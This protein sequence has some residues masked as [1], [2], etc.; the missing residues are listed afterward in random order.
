[1]DAEQTP[2]AVVPTAADR[3]R[4]MI[5]GRPILSAIL[6][7]LVWHVVQFALAEAIA[8]SEDAILKMPDSNS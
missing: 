3:A 4:A 1:M 2:R 7:T 8:R 5:A 6:L